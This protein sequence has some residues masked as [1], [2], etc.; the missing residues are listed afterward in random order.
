LAARTIGPAL[1]WLELQAGLEWIVL[2]DFLYPGHSRHRM[3]AVP[4]KTGAALQARLLA[5]AERAGI[6]I[7]TEAR[8]TRLFTAD[9]TC[10]AAVEI[11]RPGGVAE[12]VGCRALVLACN[13]Y[14]GNR[15]LVA[16]HIPEMAEALYYGH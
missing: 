16:R 11:V 1:E 3:H 12:T 13:G 5:A 9:G 2:T 8:T 10:V 14:G 6:P 15:Q 4:D 7:V